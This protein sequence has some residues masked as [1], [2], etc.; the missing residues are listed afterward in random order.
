M[1]RI[2]AAQFRW[3]VRATGWAGWIR[4]KGRSG[5]V[6]WFAFANK[7]SSFE[8]GLELEF[9]FVSHS[10]SNYTHLNSK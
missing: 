7:R 10:N 6:H 9:E 1:G 4:K 2:G 5:P 3:A 8:L